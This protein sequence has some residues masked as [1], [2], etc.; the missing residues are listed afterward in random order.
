[1]K[2]QALIHPAEDGGY[3]AEAPALRGCYSEGETIDKVARDIKEAVEGWL[4]AAAEQT[5]SKAGADS[6]LVEIEV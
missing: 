2:I 5:R 1:M 6:Q 4:E 3:W